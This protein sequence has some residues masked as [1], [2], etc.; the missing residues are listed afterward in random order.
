MS[1][2]FYDVLAC[3]EC[4]FKSKLCPVEAPNKKG[5]LCIPAKV[6]LCLAEDMSEVAAI[7]SGG[8]ETEE[9]IN[10]ALRV[11]QGKVGIKKG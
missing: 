5:K 11:I 9:I 10:R 2:R 3:A 7:A 8:L 1:N 6:A 4:P